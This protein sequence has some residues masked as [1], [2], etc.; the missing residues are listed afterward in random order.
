M[1]SGS[2]CAP[3]ARVAHHLVQSIRLDVRLRVRRAVAQ[4]LGLAGTHHLVQGQDAVVAAGERLVAPPARDW[5]DAHALSCRADGCQV[6]A[7]PKWLLQ[8]VHLLLRLD[9][10]TASWITGTRRSAARS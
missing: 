1:N 7:P 8:A 9:L 4:Q 3:V 6:S 2:R 10:S 5:L